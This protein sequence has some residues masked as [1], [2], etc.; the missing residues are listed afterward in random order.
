M[1]ESDVEKKWLFDRPWTRN[2][3]KVRQDFISKFVGGARKE[4]ELVSALDVGC[5]VGY[6]SKL[7]LEMGF[8]VVG[9][10]GR[11]E[12]ANRWKSR[13]PEITF[14]KKNVEDAVLAEMGTFDLVLSVGLLYRLENPFRA[15]RNL[16]VLTGKILLIETMCVPNEQ[17]TMHLL[18]E[19]IAEDQGLNYVAFY[20]SESCLVKMLYRAGFPFVY[21]FEQLPAD[22]LYT[23]S[24]W[25]K[26]LRTYL[27]ATTNPLKVDK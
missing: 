9:V 18:D 8:R 12:N 7:L 20:P 3:T 13:S 5:G 27:A 21:R 1:A 14:L 16:H 15:I 2:F 11:Q 19:G 23:A 6:F 25:R 26:R 22:E 4:I 17:P 10:D 24:V